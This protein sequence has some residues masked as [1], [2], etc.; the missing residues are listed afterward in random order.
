MVEEERERLGYWGQDDSAPRYSVCVC[1]YNMADTLER[2]MTS[3]LDQLDRNLYEVVVI[4][5][6]SSDSS[7]DELEKLAKSYTNFRY[8]SLPRDP[9]RKLGLTRNISIRAARGEYVLLHIDADDEWKPFLQDLVTLYHKIEGVV[10]CDIHLSGQQTGIGKRDLLLRY[11]PFENLYRSEDRNLMM[12]LA[13]ENVLL[14]LDYRLYRTRMERPVKT[15]IFKTI[16][17]DCSQMV[18]DLRQNEPSWPFIKFSL[19]L[20]FQKDRFS[21]LSKIIRPALIFPIYLL[22]RFMP[23]II[24]PISREEMIAYQEKNRGTYPE[25][26]KRLGGD[27]DMSFLS[28][29]AQEIY[30]YSAKLPGLRSSE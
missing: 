27:P 11:G 28:K 3:V 30:S 9:K 29:E 21:L 2:A 22:T 10:G 17:D 1:N 26:M 5:D 4:D 20:P 15:K 18:Y 16:W 6:G 7:L 12:K 14:F 23:P 13:K 19:M 8:F 24:N 25:V